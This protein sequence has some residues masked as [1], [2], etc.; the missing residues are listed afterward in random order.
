MER[1]KPERPPVRSAT[2]RRAMQNRHHRHLAELDL[3][4]GAV[5]EPG[6][7]DA[8]LDVALF[9]LAQVEPGGKMLAL[10]DEQH[11]ADAVGQRRE[12]GLDADDGLIV[13]RTAL[14]RAL[15]PQDGNVALPFRM[16][17]SRQRDVETA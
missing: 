6:M 7:G 1:Y 13:Q 8:L 14:V 10:A 9:Q 16:Q 2:S 4:E 3:V 15:E 17:R 12:E 11:G 5:P